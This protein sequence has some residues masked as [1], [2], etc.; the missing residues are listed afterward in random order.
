MEYPFSSVEGMNRA[1]DVLSLATLKKIAAI[2]VQVLKRVKP[3]RTE[4]D[5]VREVTSH[6]KA[7]LQTVL[8]SEAIPIDFIEPQGST[9]LKQTQLAGD[10]DVDLF[11]G[12]N[13]SLLDQ[14]KE[15]PKK[16]VREQLKSLFTRLINDVLTP[17]IN[18]TLRPQSIT[19]SYAE[20]PYISVKVDGVKFDVVFCFNLTSDF[21]EREDIVT[22]MDRTPL[23]SKFVR[24]N[25][26]DVQKDDVRLLKAFFK[27]CHVY[28]DKSAPGSMGFIGYGVEILLHFF[29]TLENVMANIP[30]LHGQPLDMFGREKDGV[31]STPRFANDFIIIID[32]TDR[33]RNVGASMDQRCFTHAV[34]VIAEFLKEPSP[35]F[36]DITPIPD[37]E[38]DD[39]CFQA[40]VFENTREAHYTIVRDKL[41]RLGN[42]ARKKLEREQTGEERFGPIVFSVV[43]GKDEL[44]V[45]IAFHVRATTIPDTF[46]QLGPSKTDARARINKY[47]QQHPDAVIDEN[48]TYY[49]MRTRRI[50]EF[51][52][53]LAKFFKDELDI[54]G[55]TLVPGVNGAVVSTSPEQ[56]VGRQ[57]IHVLK[58]MILPYMV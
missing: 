25:L 54:K 27:A 34:H 57:A 46:K 5:H 30:L 6:V 15:L 52:I 43:L 31:L 41:Y 29:G 11:I 35:E 50:T 4:V 21:I 37:P 44:Q 1:I 10:S 36:F 3:T 7:S 56:A 58:S 40:L 24:D 28:G 16:Q 18:D 20:H 47:M 32:P 9:G 13:P 33:N 17:G 12:L 45:A 8:E 2:K 42:L 51:T 53:A 14:Y 23:H 55:L 48:D 38:N 26:S 22:A 49:I 39:P 19:F